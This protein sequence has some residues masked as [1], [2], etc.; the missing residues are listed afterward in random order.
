VGLVDVDP[1][2]LWYDA[3]CAAQWASIAAWVD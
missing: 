3:I 2:H 1:E